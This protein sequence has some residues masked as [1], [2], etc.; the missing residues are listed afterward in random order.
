MVTDVLYFS[1]EMERMKNILPV[2]DDMLTPVRQLILENAKENVS[3]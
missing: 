2:S 1:L 3:S